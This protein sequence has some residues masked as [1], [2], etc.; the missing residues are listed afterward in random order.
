MFLP[1]ILSLFFLHVGTSE[2]RVNKKIVS[3]FMKREKTMN[4][5]KINSLF[6]IIQ[7]VQ[8]KLVVVIMFLQLIK[9]LTFI[10]SN[11][12]LISILH[13]SNTCVEL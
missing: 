7:K 9:K 3:I 5:L 8:L 12:P 11:F 2:Q 6:N 13:P 1:K 4:L 10:L